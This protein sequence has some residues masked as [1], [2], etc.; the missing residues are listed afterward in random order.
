LFSPHTGKR[1]PG[2]SKKDGFGGVV[3]SLLYI[4]VNDPISSY[5]YCWLFVGFAIAIIVLVCLF[6]VGL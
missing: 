5:L 2:G 4:S 1:K 6:L 3:T